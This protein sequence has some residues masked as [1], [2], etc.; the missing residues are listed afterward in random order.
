MK[1][2]LTE[3][4]IFFVILNAAKVPLAFLGVHHSVASF[5][6]LSL[7]FIFGIAFFIRQRG[8]VGDL[9][10]SIFLIYHL[11]L[12]VREFALVLV[13]G[14]GSVS[15]EAVALSSAR[16]VSIYI[17]YL[18]FRKPP[19]N[20]N[21]SAVLKVVAFYLLMTSIV[22]ALQTPLSPFSGIFSSQLSDITSGNHLGYFRSTGGVGGTVIDYAVYLS[23]SAFLLFLVR[24]RYSP[25]LLALVVFAFGFGTY[26]A[27]SRSLF[28]V[29]FAAVSSMVFTYG[30]RFSTFVFLMLAILLSANFDRI[31]IAWNSLQDLSFEISGQSDVNR[32]DGWEAALD[33]QSFFELAFGTGVGVN[34][35]FGSIGGK[36]SGDGFAVSYIVEYGLF[37]LVLLVLMIFRFLSFRYKSITLRIP[38]FLIFLFVIGVN[39]GFEKTFNYGYFFIVVTVVS[40]LLRG[41]R[42][43]PM[44]AA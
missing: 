25:L 14:G 33:N 43:D 12:T 23:F 1:F 17:L 28:V 32:H 38:I 5:L 22:S 19:E 16:S 6:Q 36:V 29:T 26:F 20:F 24:D 18:M 7:I 31:F 4:A 41:R 37:G 35:G 2:N 13:G 21:A 15:L 8:Q 3:F 34:T 9:V 42:L 40:L 27:F 30:R 10:S 44:I 39:S 11:L